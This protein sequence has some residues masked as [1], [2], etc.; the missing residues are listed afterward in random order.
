MQS[1][2]LES[3]NSRESFGWRVKQITAKKFHL[4]SDELNSS[5]TSKLLSPINLVLDKELAND[6]WTFSALR[7]MDER[8]TTKSGLNDI[9][10]QLEQIRTKIVTFDEFKNSVLL[11]SL[12]ISTLFKQKPKFQKNFHVATVIAMILEH[13][14]QFQ[15][16]TPQLNLCLQKIIAKLINE[17]QLCLNSISEEELINLQ[18]EIAKH[19]NEPTFIQTSTSKALPI[20]GTLTLGGASATTIGMALIKTGV[21]SSTAILSKI[22][23]AATFGGVIGMTIGAAYGTYGLLHYLDKCTLLVDRL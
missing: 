18:Q 15:N 23:V 4:T 11:I 2:L 13:N 16:E 5:N 17:L 6:F 20:T 3:I 12:S 21:V 9:F 10:V 22:A 8:P 1:V 14:Q 19:S 7:R